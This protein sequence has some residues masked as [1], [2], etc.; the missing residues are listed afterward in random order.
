MKTVTV[1]LEGR[2]LCLVCNGSAM[3]EAEERFGGA[4]AMVKAVAAPGRAGFDA[5]CEAVSILAEQGELVRRYMGHEARPLLDAAGLALLALPKDVPLLRQAVNMA[6]TVGF[7]RE[8]E[9]PVDVDL[10]LAELQQKKTKE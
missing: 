1:A 4:V 8:V 7:G 2:E 9:P 3:F 5:L 10:G 6:V